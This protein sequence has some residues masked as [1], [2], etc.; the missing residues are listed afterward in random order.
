MSCSWLDLLRF[1]ADDLGG[2]FL[3]GF[4]G[5]SSPLSSSDSDNNSD[6]D[7]DGRFLLDLLLPLTISAISES[8]ERLVLN[9]M[10]DFVDLSFVVAFDV[11]LVLDRILDSVDLSF[12]VDFDVGLVL[13]RMLVFEFLVIP[14]D[15][16]LLAGRR[17]DESQLDDELSASSD[18]DEEDEGDDV[19]FFFWCEAFLAEAC[20]LLSDKEGD[21][22][23]PLS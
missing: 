6:I 17:F 21:A 8:A 12:V 1:V 15:C 9:R 23:P 19:G 2:C 3:L 22:E 4:D 18:E 10:L 13:N 20:F 16:F 5:A 14:F 7:G 11:G